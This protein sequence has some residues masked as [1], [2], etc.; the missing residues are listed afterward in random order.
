MGIVALGTRLFHRIVGN[1]LGP[2]AFFLIGMTLETE[3]VPLIDQPFGKIALMVVMA[4]RTI[5]SRYR[6]V[7]DRMLHHAVGVTLKTDVRH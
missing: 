4:S 1:L 7:Q 6:R 2:E 3:G 5:P